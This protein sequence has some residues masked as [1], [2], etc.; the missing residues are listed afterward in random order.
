[1]IRKA[2]R[3]VAGVAFAIGFLTANQANAVIIVDSGVDSAT[4]HFTID[5]S[6]STV[7]HNPGLNF[8]GPLA[9][10][11]SYAISGEFDSTYSRYWW[12]YYLDGDDSG[13]LGTFL[14]SEDWLAFSNAT[15]L[16]TISP[17]GFTFPT[18][19]VRVTGSSLN[20]DEGPCSFPSDPNTYCS[21]FSNG[22]I[23]TLTGTYA[24]GTISL[25]GSMPIAGGN[26]F[27]EFAYNITASSVPEPGVLLLLLSGLTGLFFT[28]RRHL[29]TS[30]VKTP[31]TLNA[32]RSAYLPT[33]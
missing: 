11:L 9:D 14:Y 18:Y 7:T 8:F 23:A 20:G 10:P 19:F 22:S 16:G 12:K 21:G 17:T 31:R 29:R 15:I 3:A 13:S 2:L 28:S 27:E 25:Q 33:R 1:M 32:F 4:K 30:N 24:D 5:S 26:L 6:V